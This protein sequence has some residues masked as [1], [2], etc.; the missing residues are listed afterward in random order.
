MKN[1]Q[2]HDLLHIAYPSKNKNEQVLNIVYHKKGPD[3]YIYT[4]CPA[5]L[6]TLCEGYYSAM[7]GATGLV[8]V[9]SGRGRFGIFF[10][11]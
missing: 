6:S 7:G 5:T 9:Y 11:V 8:M 4:D 1:I 3:I 2:F 10:E